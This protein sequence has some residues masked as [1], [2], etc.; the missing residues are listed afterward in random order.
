[1]TNDDRELAERACTGDRAAFQ[2]L[3]ERHYDTA[4][5]FAF[6]FTRNVEDAEDIAQDVC[7]GL[8]RK[9][10]SFRGKSQFTTWLYRVVVNACRDHARKLKSSQTLQAN[11]AVFR[12]HGEAD[13]RHDADRLDWLSQAVA[14][15]EPKLRETAILVLA[16]DLSHAD[17]AKA[18]GCAESTV[19]WRMHEIRK[20]LKTMVETIND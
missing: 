17:A 10:R 1:M 14:S 7:L 18:L 20:K 12:E 9:L 3:L 2:Q 15:L 19:S 16:E 8:A 6:R 11:F 13:Q 5:R 4:Y